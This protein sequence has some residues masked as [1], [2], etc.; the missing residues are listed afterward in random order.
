M[1]DAIIHQ[2][3]IDLDDGLQILDSQVVIQGYHPPVNSALSAIILNVSGDHLDGLQRVLL[4][5]YPHDFQLTLLTQ[6]SQSTVLLNT[7]ANE[8]WESA[9]VYLP[10]LGEHVSFQ[11]AQEIFSHLRSPDGCPWDRKQTHASLRPYILEEAY[12]VIEAIDQGDTV[13]LVDELGDLMLQ[14]ILQTQVAIDHDEFK[15][16]DVLQRLNEKMIRRHPHVWGNVDV[17]GDA[18]QVKTNWEQIKQEENADKPNVRESALDGIPKALPALLVAHKYGTKAAK[19]GFDW[20]SI[21]G[22][23]DK[24]REEIDELMAVDDPRELAEEI[25]DLLFSLVNWL[26]WLGIDDAETV[27]RSANQKFYRRFRHIEEAIATN[28]NR[29]MSTYSLDELEAFWQAGKAKGL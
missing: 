18:E 23:K 28:G 6:H 8:Q 4:N 21:D 10:P 20:E 12:E 5:E 9:T 25:G 3:G 1:I 26:R 11:A 24:V 17:E 19:L 29:P 13:A 22:V 27:M 16:P 7:L 2:L 15:M 14:V